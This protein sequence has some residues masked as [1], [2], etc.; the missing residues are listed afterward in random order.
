MY[1]APD[2][3]KVELMQNGVFASTC[4]PGTGLADV[5]YSGDDLSGCQYET[6]AGEEDKYQC[7][8]V[9]DGPDDL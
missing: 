1:S 4:V 9:F 7:Y 2:F 8:Y 5:D 3:V 6:I